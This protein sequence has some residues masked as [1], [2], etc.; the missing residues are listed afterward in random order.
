MDSISS[1]LITMIAINTINQDKTI[2]FKT[3][4]NNRIINNIIN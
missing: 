3:K 2:H 1:K 4:Q